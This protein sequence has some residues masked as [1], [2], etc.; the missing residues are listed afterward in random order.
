MKESNL[1]RFVHWLVLRLHPQ[2][3]ATRADLLQQNKAMAKKLNAL[4]DENKEWYARC[5]SAEQALRAIR[6]DM[7]KS[8][9][10]RDKNHGT[11]ISWYA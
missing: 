8:I 7:K 11:N 6:S 10:L 2:L 3:A 9:E 5:M 4:R 1:Q